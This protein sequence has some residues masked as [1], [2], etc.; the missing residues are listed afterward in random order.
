MSAFRLEISRF[1]NSS[2]HTHFSLS[3]GFTP[4]LSDSTPLPSATGSGC[5]AAEDHAAVSLPVTLV[6]K[7][8][9]KYM[10]SHSIVH[11]L[12]EEP[13][14]GSDWVLGDNIYGR[15]PRIR[16]FP[17]PVPCARCYA[18]TTSWNTHNT[19][20]AWTEK[21]TEGQGGEGTGLRCTELGRSGAMIQTHQSFQSLSPSFTTP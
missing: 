19:Y 10:H 4:S 11:M 1:Q 3:V 15:K 8:I 9:F 2:G 21:E 18:Q 13:H 14:G 16:I 7:V 20:E 5:W 6:S 17:A 12:A